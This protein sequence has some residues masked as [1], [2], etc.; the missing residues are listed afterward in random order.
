MKREIMMKL[1]VGIFP[2][3]LEI[4]QW[5]YNECENNHAGCNEKCPVY[6]IYGGIPNTNEQ[7]AKYGCDCFKNGHAMKKFIREQAL[8]SIHD[9]EFVGDEFGALNKATSWLRSLGFSVGR[10]QG[11]NP[12]AVMFGNWTI[13]KWDHLDS[14]EVN[15]LDARIVSEDFRGGPVRVEFQDTHTLIEKIKEEIR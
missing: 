12:I 8:L 15:S 11:Q 13:Q 9:R 5:L 1:A 14:D 3:D 10:M 6:K 2:T 7:G 4:E